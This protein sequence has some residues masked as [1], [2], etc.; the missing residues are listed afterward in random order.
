MGMKTLSQLVSRH[1]LPLC[2]VLVCELSDAQRELKVS[3]G[4][5]LVQW[6]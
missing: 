4:S 1:Y 3:V 5:E 2:Q 6:V